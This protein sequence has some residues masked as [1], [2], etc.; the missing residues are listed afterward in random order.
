MADAMGMR[1]SMPEVT[2]AD[3]LASNCGYQL[4]LAA[5][6][7]W[8]LSFAVAIETQPDLLS[9]MNLASTIIF[10]DEAFPIPPI[11]RR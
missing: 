1:R 3:V 6:S 5:A 7:L 8:M 10:G 9:R 4:S 2:L 11:P